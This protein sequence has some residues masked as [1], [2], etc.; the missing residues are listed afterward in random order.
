MAWVQA[1]STRFTM[2]PPVSRTFRTVFFGRSGSRSPGTDPRMGGSVPGRLKKLKGAALTRSSFSCVVP[3]AIGR[4]VTRPSGGTISV[5]GALAGEIKFHFGAV[6]GERRH[7]PRECPAS[8]VAALRKNGRSDESGVFAVSAREFFAPCSVFV[9]GAVGDDHGFVG[10][11]VPALKTFGHGDVL[12]APFDITDDFGITDTA[13]KR[14]IGE[15]FAEAVIFA[16]VMAASFRLDVLILLG[17]R[18]G[19]K[20]DDQGDKEKGKSFHDRAESRLILERNE[21]LFK[22]KVRRICASHRSFGTAAVSL[23][24]PTSRAWRSSAERAIRFPVRRARMP[25]GIS[26]QRQFQDLAS[27]LGDVASFSVPN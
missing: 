27:A 21:T 26:R 10:L 23:P 18:I 11:V 3:R 14:E 9:S 5:A 16:G 17:N 4:R 2:N 8:L 24:R 20:R 22:R 12:T 7:E 13:P 6:N 19:A 1:S 25:R 15:D